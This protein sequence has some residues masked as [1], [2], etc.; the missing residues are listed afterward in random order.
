ML[1]RRLSVEIVTCRG[2]RVTKIVDSRFDWLDLLGVSI[3][4]S[5]DYNSS[6]I[7]LLLDNESLTIPSVIK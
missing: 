7:A 4:I 3:T 1:S 5:L 2:V 6:H